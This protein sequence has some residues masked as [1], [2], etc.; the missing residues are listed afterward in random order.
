MLPR[1]DIRDVAQVVQAQLNQAGFRVELKN[2]EL[3]QF[4]QDWR[5]SNFEA[6]AST[7]AGS[8]DPDDY[9]YR[10]FRTG[11][12][13]NVFKYTNPELDALLDQRAHHARRGQRAGDVQ[14]G[15]AHPRLPGPIAHLAYGQL[16]TAV[17]ANVQGYEMMR[18][19]LAPLPAARPRWRADGCHPLLAPGGRVAKA[20]A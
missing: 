10:T 8:P 2:Q 9:F 5:N 17:R 20:G 6:F 11:G 15:A 18:Q 4:I 3:G 12:S 14:R 16:F 7:N 1:Q 19:P 13:T